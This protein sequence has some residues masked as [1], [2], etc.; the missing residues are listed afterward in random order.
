MC[1]LADAGG[2]WPAGDEGSNEE[3]AHD[4]QKYTSGQKAIET[5]QCK[6]KQLSQADKSSSPSETV[7]DKNLKEANNP[8]GSVLSKMVTM[9]SK[10][11]FENEQRPLKGGKAIKKSIWPMKN[12]SIVQ[13][14]RCRMISSCHYAFITI[15]L[16]QCDEQ[17]VIKHKI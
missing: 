7:T 16:P 13:S 6:N 17:Q 1:I 2:E 4:R 14:N 5:G 9:P 15:I 11:R 12:D 8:T 3:L 10:S